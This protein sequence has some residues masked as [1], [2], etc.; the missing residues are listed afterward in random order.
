LAARESLPRSTLEKMNAAMFNV[1]SEGVLV[2]MDPAM[3][4]LDNQKRQVRVQVNAKANQLELTVRG[5]VEEIFKLRGNVKQVCL[6]AAR[7]YLEALD[8]LSA[9][10]PAS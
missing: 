5:E 4:A 8:K 2:I 3:G 10:D 9:G 7:A 1:S 6:D